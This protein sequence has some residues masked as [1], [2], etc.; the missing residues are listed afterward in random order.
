MPSALK[1]RFTRL[2][3][4]GQPTLPVCAHFLLCVVISPAQFAGSPSMGNRA[5]RWNKRTKH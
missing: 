3:H 4:S 1:S 5:K 2:P